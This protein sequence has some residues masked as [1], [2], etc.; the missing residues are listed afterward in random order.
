MDLFWE[1][2]EG[3]TGYNVYRRLEG[4]QGF[5]LNPSN[6]EPLSVTRY[7]DLNV[8]NDIKYILFGEGG[9]ESGQD[10][11]RGKGVSW[12]SRDPDQ[13]YSTECAR[14]VGSHSRQGGDRVKL[15]EESGGRHS[16]V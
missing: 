15:E 8:H 7:T 9:E 11:R 2:V 1:P 14:C 13:A 10:R 3:A 16:R 12:F 5:P 6:R 4:E